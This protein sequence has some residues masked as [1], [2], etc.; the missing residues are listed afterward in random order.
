MHIAL[1]LHAAVYSFLS[2]LKFKYLHK[3]KIN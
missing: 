2:I 1:F 3:C